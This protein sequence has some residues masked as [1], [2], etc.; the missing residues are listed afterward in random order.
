MRLAALALDYDGTIARDG[1][2]DPAVRDA[3]HAARA[4]GVAVL[5][6]TGRILADLRR[7]AGDLGLFD[8][9]VAENGAVVHFPPSGRTLDLGQPPPASFLAG[10]AA[11]GVDARAGTCVVEMD[12]AHGGAALALLRELELPLVVL[13]NR[14]RLMVLPQ[15]ISKAS[16]LHEVLR[17]LRL[18]E[19]S[20]AAIGDAENDHAL[21]E[22][23]ELGAAVAWGS[24]ALPAVADEVIPGDGPSW[25]SE[26]RSSSSPATT[27]PGPVSSPI[28]R[29]IAS[30]VRP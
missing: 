23:C 29:A 4:A 15:G 28:S 26:R 13:F 17:T 11:R 9:V 14:G 12:A 21:L 27:R 25:S 30:A 19:H 22:A 7:V 18:S 6:V 8:A 20:A 16:G 5:L 10:L 3:L 2:L 24:P 1:V